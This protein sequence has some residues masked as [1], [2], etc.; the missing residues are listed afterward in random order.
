MDNMNFPAPI[1][2][3]CIILSSIPLNKGSSDVVGYKM[4]PIPFN[5]DHR[6]LM[7]N[8][9]V[10]FVVIVLSTTFL[11]NSVLITCFTV[12]VFLFDTMI[13]SE[14]HENVCTIFK[15]KHI[16]LTCL[17]SMWILFH[18]SFTLLCLIFFWI[19]WASFNII[20]CFRISRLPDLQL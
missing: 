20:Y 10:S 16:T 8:S 6:S 1:S 18:D 7:Q 11:N 12:V 2:T 14:H 13:I 17:W 3:V 9:G 5:H 15:N 19:F 4:K